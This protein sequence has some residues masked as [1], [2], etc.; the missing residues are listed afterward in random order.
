METIN[1]IKDFVVKYLLILYKYKYITATAVF[2][3]IIVLLSE[4]NLIE[5]IDNNNKISKLKNEIVELDKEIKDY[6]EK[7]NGLSN[8][9]RIIEKVARE[10]YGMHGEN[11]EVFIM[12]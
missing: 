6:E 8:D 1:R 10:E 12:E 5:H 3:I 11:E 4:H 9:A 2:V 7:I